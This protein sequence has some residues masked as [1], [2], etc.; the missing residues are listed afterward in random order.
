MRLGSLDLSHLDTVCK[1]WPHYSP[2]YRPVVASMITLNPSCGVF[3]RSEDGSEQ[4]AAMI[5]QSDYGGLGILQTV[6]E[7]RRRG[8]A[9]LALRQQTK[10]LGLAGVNVHCHVIVNN[11]GSLE[12]FKRSGLK[13][14]EI[15]NWVCVEERPQNSHSS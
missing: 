14:V 3:V 1:Y 11:F 4:L 8:F 10:T 13:I 9:L 6:P 12:L 7:F 5:L 15:S 2:D